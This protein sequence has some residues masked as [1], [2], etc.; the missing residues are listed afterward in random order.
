M[1]CTW[2]KVAKLSPAQLSRAA[3]QSVRLSLKSN[4]LS[5]AF[6]VANSVRYAGFVPT[7]TFDSIRLKLAKPKFQ[8][9]AQELSSECPSRLVVHTLLHGLLRTG[10]AEKASNLAHQMMQAGIRVRTKSLESV[11]QSL[12][13]TPVSLFG[14]QKT[15][16]HRDLHDLRPEI[17]GHPGTQHAVR[18]LQVARQ[19]RQKRTHSMFKTLIA[20]CLINGEIIIAALVFGILVR[21]WEAQQLAARYQETQ[22]IQEL[23]PRP[24]HSRLKDICLSIEVVTKQKNPEPMDLKVALQSLTI[25]AELLDQHLFPFHNV[26]PLIHTMS[27]FWQ[28]PERVWR[29][30]IDSKVPASYII[31]K[32]LDR[33]IYKLPD[34]PPDVRSGQRILPPLHQTSYNAL[35]QYA[36]RYRNYPRFAEEVLDH[37]TV[38]RQPRLELDPVGRNIIKRS[39]V[40]MRR[41][42]IRELLKEREGTPPEPQS[43]LCHLLSLV[44]KD[45]LRTG[46][47]ANTYSLTTQMANLISTGKPEVVVDAIPYLLPSTTRDLVKAD[48]RQAV[49]LGPFVFTNIL[50]AIYKADRVELAEKVWR[51]ARFAEKQSWNTHKFEARPWCLPVEAYT[52]MLS[53]CA[54]DAKRALK[55]GNTR[56]RASTGIWGKALLNRLCLRYFHNP[57]DSH[58]RSSIVANHGSARY[59]AL[60]VYRRLLQVPTRLEHKMAVLEANPS[61]TIRVGKGQLE[62]PRPDERFFNA[63]LDVVGQCPPIRS[64]NGR[65]RAPRRFLRM[66][67]RSR[68]RMLFQD[69]LPT[70]KRDGALVEVAKNM[71]QCGVPIP[72]KYRHTLLGQVESGKWTQRAGVVRVR[73]EWTKSSWNRSRQQRRFRR[74]VLL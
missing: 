66:E 64:P 1:Q 30:D 13:T 54:K 58:G 71:V 34:K 36:L 72:A 17:S 7:S 67:A 29:R 4:N 69:V 55:N 16:K 46:L 61:V 53:I 70:T 9:I 27:P 14:P 44:D 28:S 73:V 50:N 10:E 62:V 39:E 20:L 49:A 65:R 43:D 42:H 56:V 37:M 52:I 47:L 68:F 18:L 59:M 33:L 38:R 48:V 22:P 63:M 5:D 23:T 11:F 26:T 21:D 74:K 24:S 15:F 41:P 57:N 35:L 12:S 3:S 31:H 8:P 40:L 2:Q 25:L 19:T 32:T 6:T 51:L 60:L 45:A